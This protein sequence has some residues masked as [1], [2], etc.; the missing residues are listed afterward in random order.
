MRNLLISELPGLST[1]IPE[2]CGLSG[3]TFISAPEH[4]SNIEMKA[5]II[6]N[7]KLIVLS[8]SIITKITLFFFSCKTI[9]GLQ[10]HFCTPVLMFGFIYHAFFQCFANFAQHRMSNESDDL[11]R[12]V[13]CSGIVCGNGISVL[14]I[15]KWVRQTCILNQN[16]DMRFWTD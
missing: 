9:S 2:A 1:I 12:T 6:R 4:D 10:I 7:R 3:M 15:R 14:R 5:D 8:V 13:S 11:M 16:Q